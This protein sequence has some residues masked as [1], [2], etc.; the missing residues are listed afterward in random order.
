MNCKCG[1]RMRVNKT[2]TTPEVTY[3]IYKCDRCGRSTCSE[4]KVTQDAR[5]KMNENRRKGLKIDII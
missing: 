1:N 3:R 4:E 5:K 2:V